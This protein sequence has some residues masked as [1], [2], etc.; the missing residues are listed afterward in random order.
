MRTFTWSV[1]LVLAMGF[2]YVPSSV[3]AEEVG[4]APLRHSL[5]VHAAD[6]TALTRW[7][8]TEARPDDRTLLLVVESPRFLGGARAPDLLSQRVVFRRSYGPSQATALAAKI[9]EFR[10]DAHAAPVAEPLF[11]GR[12]AKPLWVAA[13]LWTAAEETA[14]GNWLHESVSANYLV[15]S[16]LSVDCADTAVALRWIY[17]RDHAL[18]AGNQLSGSGALVG[19]FSRSDAW[20]RLATHPD[21]RKDERFKAA[22][23]YVLENTYTHSIAGDLYPIDIASAY[24]A[25]GTVHLNLYNSTTG[26]TETILGIGP[27]EKFCPKGACI[28]TVWG[29]EPSQEKVFVSPIITFNPKGAHGGFMR[30][31]WPEK[32]KAGNWF[33]RKGTGMPG[34][35]LTQYS[36]PDTPAYLYEAW[37]EEKIGLAADPHTQLDT[38]LHFIDFLA[39]ERTTLVLN[40]MMY[41]AGG[42]CAPGSDGYENYSTPTRD[43]RLRDLS[44][45]FRKIA[46][47]LPAGDTFADQ[48]LTN[49]AFLTYAGFSRVSL[50]ELVTDRGGI[51]ERLSSDPNA[52]W[53][54]RWGMPSAQATLDDTFDTQAFVLYRTFALRR[55]KAA[56]GFARCQPYESKDAPCDLNSPAIRALYTTVEDRALRTLGAWWNVWVPAHS[57]SLD[58]KA[59]AQA[60]DEFDSQPI[61]SSSACAGHEYE[62]CSELDLLG[63]ARDALG[64]MSDHPYAKW[65]ARWGVPDP[66]P[67]PD[68]SAR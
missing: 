22:I 9:L 26:H 16:G 37:V 13:R 11:S 29:N 19:H 55:E 64:A 7:I 44:L 5:V 18:P 59:I 39:G 49:N 45:E 43:Q 67:G 41:C 23:R 60:K 35:S 12:V 51:L 10:R 52:P 56:E 2:G 47:T 53:L 61:V 31:R 36:M 8:L 40:A 58:P 3:R 68:N 24:V 27:D 15:G 38:R 20:E 14:F 62:E 34:Y 42:K 25:P 33:L 28:T 66:S 63:P 17:A 1:I 4:T 57:G 50:P 21:W 54:E 32:N 30:W 46:A 6:G 48:L 65:P